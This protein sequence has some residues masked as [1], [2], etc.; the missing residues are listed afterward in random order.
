M[1][2]KNLVD[3]K[4]IHPYSC[5]W[6]F[7]ASVATSIFCVSLHYKSPLIPVS[8]CLLLLPGWVLKQ[9]T[10]YQ[11]TTAI[12]FVLNY[13]PNSQISYTDHVS[14]WDFIKLKNSCIVYSD[15]IYERNTKLIMQADFQYCVRLY[16][17]FIR[18]WLRNLCAVL[19]SQSQSYLPDNISILR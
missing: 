3:N 18:W 7:L 12:G 16:A 8:L 17:V 19:Y 10:V 6:C 5:H 11:Y 1:E 2:K 15:T 9:F 4:P 14:Y 13:K